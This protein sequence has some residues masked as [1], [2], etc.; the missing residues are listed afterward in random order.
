MF[1]LTEGCEKG[2][3]YAPGWIPS[4]FSSPKGNEGIWSNSTPSHPT[5]APAACRKRRSKA[6]GGQTQTLDKCLWE[7]TLSGPLKRKYPGPVFCTWNKLW[8]HYGLKPNTLVW[9]V[10]GSFISVVVSSPPQSRQ[11]I[12]AHWCILCDVGTWKTGLNSFFLFFLSQKPQ[13]IQ[14]WVTANLKNN[15][16]LLNKLSVP[17][18]IPLQNIVF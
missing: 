16:I 17:Q 6:Q 2:P 5:P 14:L 15:P 12:Q 13:K 1:P 9:G 11:Q 18:D 10:E 4:S 8:H 3:V 7:K